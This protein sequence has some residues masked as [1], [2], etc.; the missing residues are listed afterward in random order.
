MRS[1][2]GFGYSVGILRANISF[3]I[4]EALSSC[5]TNGA[6]SGTVNVE[7][8]LVELP[9]LL[10]ARTHKVYEFKL[11]RMKLI[12]FVPC[13]LVMVAPVAVHVKLVAPGT[14]AT[15][16]VPVAKRIVAPVFVI[17]PGCAGTAVDSVVLLKLLLQPF[18]AI[19]RTDNVPPVN[20]APA[21]KTIELPVALPDILVPVGMVHWNELAP[22]TAATE[23]VLLV[24]QN[25]VVVPEITPGVANWL[26]IV[27]VLVV[28]T[29]PHPPEEAV[30]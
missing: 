7:H 20:P 21:T 8:L 10:F 19:A 26:V 12:L 15:E 23:N 16:A 13:P 24:L 17:V 1:L 25:P 4:L 3:S 14:L 11:L 6:A 2:A 9:Q 27:T 5:S 22:G 29:L 28:L 18:E 30:V